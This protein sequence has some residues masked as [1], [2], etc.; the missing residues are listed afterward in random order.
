M[1][2]KHPVVMQVQRLQVVESIERICIHM[3]QVIPA[4][5]Q[6]AQ[7]CQPCHTVWWNAVDTVVWNQREK[8]KA[9]HIALITISVMSQLIY[10]TKDFL[11][12]AISRT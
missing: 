11:N 6:P 9:F 2:G 4:Q 7:G 8:K 5:L 1:Y 10:T 3:N 12:F